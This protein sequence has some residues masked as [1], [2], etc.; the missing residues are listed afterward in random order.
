VK[1]NSDTPMPTPAP[2]ITS[3]SIFLARL[4]WVI[5]GPM[6]LLLVIV[7]LV[8]SKEA[9]L[10]GLDALYG[11]VV[12][13]ML[14]GRWLEQRSAAPKTASGEPATPESFRMYVY[15]LIAVSI[16]AWLGAKLAV[17]LLL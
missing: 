5:F 7:G 14:A 2:E 12:L 9:G 3:I 8:S 11:I 17:R 10:T 13:L 1:K 4:C 15:I 6:T 16:C